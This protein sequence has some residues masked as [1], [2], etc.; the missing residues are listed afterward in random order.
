MNRMNVSRNAFCMAVVFALIGCGSGGD[1]DGNSGSAKEWMDIPGVLGADCNDKSI[2]Q[3]SG[4]GNE[5][6][7]GYCSSIAK[8]ATGEARCDGG[9]LQVQ[10]E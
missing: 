9:R 3:V 10:C 1:G 7:A 4:R 6:A 8:K 2:Q 5:Y